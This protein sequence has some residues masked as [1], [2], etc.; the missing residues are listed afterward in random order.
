[1]LKELETRNAC[2]E[3]AKLNSKGKSVKVGIKHLID[4][5]KLSVC[6]NQISESVNMSKSERLIFK[7]F[8]P[9]CL[10]VN[11]WKYC[12]NPVQTTETYVE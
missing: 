4:V 9:T 3:R 10:T 8:T 5:L 2:C 6:P 11:H 7:S 1:M 12:L